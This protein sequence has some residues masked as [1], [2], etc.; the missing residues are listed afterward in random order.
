MR[1]ILT[2][3]LLT[4]FL[5][6]IGQD[7][8]SLRY[9]TSVFDQ[10]TKHEDIIY[11]NSDW[12]DFLN[13][14]DPQPM[15][16]DIYEPTGD[17][18]EKRPLVLFLYGGG[19]TGG[20]KTDADVVT[21]CDSLARAGYVAVGVNYR[22]GFNFVDS[23]SSV[24]AVYRAIQDTRAAIRYM[25]EFKDQYRIDT[26]HIYLGGKSAGA[27]TAIHTVFYADEAD[28]PQE[29]F[30]TTFEP[31]DLGCLDCAGNAYAHDF[32]IKGLFGMWGAIQ[33][34]GKI[35]PDETIPTLMVHG[36][37]DIVVPMDEGY[38]YT[39]GIQLTFPY[40][41][42]SLSIHEH[43]NDIGLYNE[44]YEYEYDD[45]DVYGSNPFPNENWEPIYGL[46]RT[47]L[48]NT[49]EFDSPQPEGEEVACLGETSFYSVPEEQGATYCWSISGG[50]IVSDN[51]NEV[52]VLWD[53]GGGTISLIEQNPIGVE[54]NPS[55]SLSVSTV[56]QPLAGMEVQD[57]G[58][59]TF[60]VVDESSGSIEYSLD[61]GDGSPVQ[62]VPA[63][64]SFTYEYSSSGTFV[65]TQT[66]QN[67]CG[68]ETIT[69]EVTVVITSLEELVQEE[70]RMFPSIIQGEKN[71]KFSG[72]SGKS[73]NFFVFDVTG[74]LV[75]SSLG[76]QGDSIS[77]N[78]VDSGVYVVH[79]IVN[80]S[81]V[82]DK[83]YVD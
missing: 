57:L 2:L 50:E 44:F 13:Q 65:I 51:G 10:V 26:E 60:F 30:G 67:S 15:A 17:T 3:T 59:N 83:I 24:R 40:V 76:Y 4:F 11:G 80:E 20:D 32:E 46:T 63:G 68:T 29:T 45:H 34:L 37:G 12:Y 62:V 71:I 28:R 6:S 19:F 52:E 49:M 38:P 55:S 18:A 82:Y 1:Y 39:G 5:F 79:L 31:Q 36:D 61:M 35:T 21:W 73:F 66:V 16:M 69:Y 54:G 77:L 78:S 48:F 43:M 74:K 64:E 8:S 72:L 81:I 58:N 75:F 27:I 7:C 56:P 22:L 41:Y 42:G 53:E 25:I 9:Q 47:F 70:I 33:D 14:N 23:G